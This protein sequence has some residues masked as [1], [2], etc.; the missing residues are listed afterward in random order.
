MEGYDSVICITNTGWKG[1]QRDNIFVD[2][3]SG[4]LPPIEGA[5]VIPI[6]A[7]EQGDLI[8]VSQWLIRRS[9]PRP[10]KDAGNPRVCCD[11][12]ATPRRK[13]G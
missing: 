9:L 4:S 7:G 1:T 5:I 8:F 12:S 3:R 13:I 6:L 11:T 10:V 2:H